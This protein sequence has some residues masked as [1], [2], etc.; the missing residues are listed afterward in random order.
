[1]GYFVKMIEDFRIRVFLTVVSERG[2]K[3]A[4]DVLGISQ[5]AVSQRIAD[6]EKDL[7]VKLFTRNR[8]VGSVSSADT[9]TDL[10]Q[11]ETRPYISL[12]EAGHLFIPFAEK[13][14]ASFTDA[15]TIFTPYKASKPVRIATT[16]FVSAS[17]LPA[18]LKSLSATT[19]ASFVTDIFPEG[20]DFEALVGTAAAS[21]G[22]I[23]TNA[24]LGSPDDLFHPYRDSEAFA[25]WTS[26]EPGSS[27]SSLNQYS[28]GKS[29]LGLVVHTAASRGLCE[30]PLYRSLRHFLGL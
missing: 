17:S 16:S 25:V 14:A 21:A 23:Q 9:Q 27:P 12:T 18:V 6:L 19:G 8:L 5:S 20:T 2:F 10:D 13:I 3:K 26:F 24:K 4:A 28:P 15:S 30:S 22:T 7:G 11:K 29:G 1:M